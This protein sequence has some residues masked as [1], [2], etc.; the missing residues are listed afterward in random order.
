MFSDMSSLAKGSLFFALQHFAISLLPQ[1]FIFKVEPKDFKSSAVREC[2]KSSSKKHLIIF[3]YYVRLRTCTVALRLFLGSVMEY[4]KK[5]YH[6][7][8]CVD[9]QLIQ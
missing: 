6:D 1:I 9:R 7:H 2:R 4:E 3:C 8:Y 5:T